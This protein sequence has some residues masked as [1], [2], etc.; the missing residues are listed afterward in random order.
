MAKSKPTLVIIC[1]ATASGKTDFAIHLAQQLHTDIISVDSRQ[2][3]KELSIGTAKPSQA[4][5]AAIPHHFINHCSIH[6]TYNSG[7]F[8][9]EAIQLLATLFEKNSF[10]IA[11]GGTGL[12][13]KAICDGLDDLPKADD[14]LRKQLQT[15]LDI[16]GIDF[17]YHKLETLDKRGSL[18]VDKKNPHR[19]IR[20]IEL[21]TN[22]N[23]S[24]GSMR[25]NSKVERPFNIYKVYMDIERSV[26]YQRINER[27]DMMIENGLV[28]EAEG[29]IAHKNLQALQTVGYSELF[30]YFEGKYNLDEAI[31]KIKQHTR[32]YAKRQ[33]TWFKKEENII[34]YSAFNV[35][36]LNQ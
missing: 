11:A 32:N 25:T 24:L 15:E 36:Q 18:L 19:I 10:V 3:Y 14:D 31:E 28:K 4:Q 21:L 13:I 30:D 26:L 1:G 29:L 17:L 2:V 22:S 27:V 9:K 16:N 6:D 7:I 12:Y 8:E 23:K 20:A 33:I 5:L 35:N 34:P